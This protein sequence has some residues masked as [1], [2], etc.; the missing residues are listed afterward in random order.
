MRKDICKLIPTVAMVVAIAF[1]TIIVTGY[2]KAQTYTIL[3]TFT[4]PDGAD[5]AAAMIGDFAGNLY[6]ATYYGGNG[7]LCGGTVGCGTVFKLSSSGVETLLYTFSGGADGA[8]PEGLFRDSA[9]NL[10]GVTGHGGNLSLCNVLG[11]PPGCGVIFKLS[12]PATFCRSVMCPWRET[13]LHTFTG[14]DGALPIGSLVQ[15]SAGTFYG[16]TVGGGTDDNGTVFELNSAGQESVL[17]SFMYDAPGGSLP[18]AGLVQDS[19]GMLYGTT[20]YG[21]TGGYGVVY[22]LDPTTGQETVLYSFR[23]VDDG[24]YP[25]GPLIFDQAANIYGST[26]W[27]GFFQ[28]E[29]QDC[30]AGCGVIYKL[31]ANGDENVLYTFT[32]G[33]DGW[34]PSEELTRDTAGNL[35]GITFYGGNEQVHGCNPGGCGTIFKLDAN[36]NKTVLHAFDST[37]G[38]YPGTGLV[39]DTAGNLYGATSAGGEGSCQIIGGCGV[40]FKITP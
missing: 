21:G 15:D 40:V 11:Y 25:N 17:L 24:A 29:G 3:H 39:Q 19:A 1:V 30:Y 12:P 13:V 31:D 37:D 36:G 20:H 32:G 34:W 35:Y 14:P 5:P 22:K 26:E 38:A 9:G 16:V 23:G 6:G 4:G 27:G 10:Y 18:L 7:N 8:L 33:A 2:A 28:G